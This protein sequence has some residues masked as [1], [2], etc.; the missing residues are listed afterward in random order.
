[1]RRNQT[2]PA[3]VIAGDPID[4]AGAHRWQVRVYYEDTDAGGVVFYANYLKFM[5]RA[6]TEWLRAMGVSQ[7]ELVLA[8]GVM[9][10]VSQL[11]IQYLRPA[12]LDDAL[13]IES[14]VTQ[15]GK[16]SLNF[17]QRVLKGSDTLAQGNI[18]VG[19]VDTGSL[20]PTALPVTL[21]DQIFSVTKR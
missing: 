11:D 6:R 14:V 4:W 18:R 5:E 9:F 17:A 13:V 12:R 21:R 20:K 2:E 1:M 19:C 10:V 7:Q 15:A 8:S 3:R 16:A